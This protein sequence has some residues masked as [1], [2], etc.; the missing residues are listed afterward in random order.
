MAGSSFNIRVGIDSTLAERGLASIGRSAS[1]LNRRLGRVA[2]TGLKFAAA[3]GAA[4][5]AFA[6][7]GAIRFIKDSS[8]VAADFE[9]MAMGFESILG[10]SEK[11]AERI[12]ELTEFSVVTPFEP[13]ELMRAS[14]MLQALGGDTIAVGDGLRLIGDAS[15]AATQ[16]L[17]M[18]ALHAGRLF[19]GLTQGTA[20][21]ES[22]QQL[23]Q[24]GVLAK[25]AFQNIRELNQEQQKGK[26]GA[27]SNAEALGVMSSALGHVGGNME[28]LAQTTSGKVS[29]MRGNLGLLKVAFGQGINDGLQEGIDAMNNKLPEYMEGATR[30]GDAIGK[31]IGQAFQGNT[32]LLELQV[33]FIFMKLGEIASAVFLKVLTESVS[34]GMSSFLQSEGMAGK[35]DAS[36]KKIYEEGDVYG[37]PDGGISWALW[38]LGE[39][40]K[41]DAATPTDIGSFIDLTGNSLGSEQ[42]LQEIRDILANSEDVPE[43]QGIINKAFNVLE[44]QP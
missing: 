39:W 28:K 27:M 43:K 1:R 37:G 26:L 22:L 2:A 44:Y 3:V 16:P 11:A 5:T 10:S 13:E 12:K 17:E 23:Q 30:L 32:R 6:A 4:G 35:R 40:I 42:L 20:V 14:K 31:G 41:P 36:G 29:T 25:G 38:K 34:K 9:A 24:M 18:V 8:K 15:A 33:S 21:G 19:M 7:F